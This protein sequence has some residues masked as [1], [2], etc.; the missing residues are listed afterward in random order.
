MSTKI[1]T[2]FFFTCA[3]CG[4]GG[5]KDYALYDNTH[6]SVGCQCRSCHKMTRAKIEKGQVTRTEKA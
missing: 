6:S 1:G 2:S 4:A 3:H 5:T